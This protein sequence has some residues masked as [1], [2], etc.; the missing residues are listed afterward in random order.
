MYLTEADRQRGG[1]VATPAGRIQGLCVPLSCVVEFLGVRWECTAVVAAAELAFGT[2]CSGAAEPLRTLPEAASQLEELASAFGFA[3]PPAAGA[4]APQ[5]C[6]RPTLP[7]SV[8][9]YTADVQ[10]VPDTAAA[11]VA[12]RHSKAA[13]RM[14]SARQ[15]RSLRAW[16]QAQTATLWSAFLLPSTASGPGLLETLPRDHKGLGPA[17]AANSTSNVGEGLP[18][19]APHAAAAGGG[20]RGHDS[21]GMG[22]SRA[23]WAPDGAPASELGGAA[24]AALSRPHGTARPELLFGPLATW[25]RPGRWRASSTA[26]E[27]GV[28]ERGT[29]AVRVVYVD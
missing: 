16:Q 23:R 27:S 4:A 17:A 9:I 13:E 8:R 25:A 10:Y 24:D 12:E 18:A 29:S 15:Q 2:Y 5:P 19:P 1:G 3:P 21:G 20:G 28:G 11:L 22:V 14:S 6:G 26:F 7:R